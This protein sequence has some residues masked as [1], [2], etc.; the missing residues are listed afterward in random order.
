MMAAL[1]AIRL[2]VQVQIGRAEAAALEAAAALAVAASLVRTLPKFLSP[3]LPA[4]LE[5]TLNP[6]VR[7]RTVET[8]FSL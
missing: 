4:M 8:N 5:H 6:L 1:D 3:Y 2:P 7:R